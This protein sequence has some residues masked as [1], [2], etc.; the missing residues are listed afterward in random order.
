MSFL[1]DRPS[2]GPRALR[3]HFALF[4]VALLLIVP[5]GNAAPI[6]DPKTPAVEDLALVPADAQMVMI[7]RVAEMWKS[8][9]V[10]EITKLFPATPDNPL[11]QLEKEIGLLPADI[12]RVTL[13]VD[14]VIDN[15]RQKEAIIVLTNKRIDEKKVLESFAKRSGGKA[16]ERKAGTKG[17]H[18]F[19]MVGATNLDAVYFASDR[20][21]LIGHD[22]QV[23]AILEKPT[24]K[25]QGY[26]ATTMARANEKKHQ[27]VVGI[28]LPR[29]ALDDAKK[30][31]VDDYK[32][33][34]DTQSMV[35][36]G[37]VVKNAI[38]LEVAG[39][40]ADEAT[41]RDAKKV[42]EEGRLALSSLIDLAKPSI[43]PEK[44]IIKQVENFQVMLRNGTVTL[45]GKDVVFKS[46]IEIEVGAFK[47]MAAPFGGP[48]PAPVPPPVDPLPVDPLSA[49][50][51]VIGD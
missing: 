13:L 4:A 46:K 9:L 14:S 45:S 23:K 51:D 11:T 28:L 1:P 25:Y 26:L 32:I 35:I 7:V 37:N 20:V 31:F 27:L 39:T 24:T 43:P 15:K 30:Q 8:D 29:S 42:V 3:R 38:E 12:E 16:E 47:K 49:V 17:Y 33:L 10:K 18:A 19:K 48:G 44:E 50:P 21:M 40:F 34:A 22:S 36:A 5:A 2:Q 6:R 41:A